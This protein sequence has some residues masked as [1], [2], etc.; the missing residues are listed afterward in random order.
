MGLFDCYLAIPKEPLA[1]VIMHLALGPMARRLQLSYIEELVADY[2]HIILM[3][4]MN[5]PLETLVK[6]NLLKTKHL[7]PLIIY[8]TPFRVG[9][10]D[11][12]LTIYW[13]S[14]GQDK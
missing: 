2:Q 7:R 9:N 10:H 13:L 14:L 8:T 3:G 4:D 11:A 1:L 12:I 5:C 6:T